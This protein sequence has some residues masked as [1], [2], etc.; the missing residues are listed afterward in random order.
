MNNLSFIFPPRPDAP[1]RVLG[2][3]DAP[4]FVAAD[5]C[6]ILGIAN[7]SDALSRLDVD[8]M[9]LVSTEGQKGRG[10]AR[11]L[12]AVTESGMWALVLS[13]RKPAARAFRRWVTGEVLPAIRRTGRYEGASTSQDAPAVRDFPA[14]RA[15]L[16]NSM[17]RVLYGSTGNRAPGVRVSSFAAQDD[18]IRGFQGIAKEGGVTMA[19][20]IRTVAA[21]LIVARAKGRKTATIALPTLG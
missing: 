10:G 9:T 14:P 1:V 20:L 18:L 19:E 12:N 5:V 4:M 16:S 7:V 2:T 3:P 8:E 17:R 11:S 21:A 15:K 13:S 6:R